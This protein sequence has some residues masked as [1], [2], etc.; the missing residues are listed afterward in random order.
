[1]ICPNAMTGSQ[2]HRLPRSSAQPASTV[3]SPRYI[4]LRVTRFESLAQSARELTEGAQEPRG[5]VRVGAPADFF[6]W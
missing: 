5:K 2:G 1:M 3:I 4:G 6:N